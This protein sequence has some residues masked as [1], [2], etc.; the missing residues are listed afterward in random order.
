[1]SW[2]QALRFFL[3]EASAS[4]RRGWRTSFLAVVTIA[5]S[6]FVVG[7]FLLL[8]ANLERVA[9]EWRREARAIVYFAAGAGREERDGIAAQVEAAS[10]VERV[11]RVSSAEAEERFAAAF[12]GL[13]DLLAGSDGEPLPESLEIVYD[14]ERVEP[15]ARRRWLDEL[16]GRAAVEVVDDDHLWLAEIGQLALLL[17][18]LGT[19]LGGAL[20]AA[21]VF[22]IASVI[23]LT[24]Y[25]YRDE[26]AV[27][28]L[29]GATEFVIRGPFLVEGL[30]QGLLGAVLAVAALWGAFGLAGS[31]ALPEVLGSV[32]FGRFLS[33]ASLVAIVALG[34]L[35]GLV[36]AA[37][38]IRRERTGA[39]GAEE[40][41]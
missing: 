26:I 35:A 13:G 10:W 4:L 25:R 7:A 23:R 38:S 21:A 9:R 15:G 24:A 34:G 28:R 30:L 32:L 6:L 8:T 2:L 33:A 37:L 19:L 41:G 36:G 18:G 12:P 39:L 31:R 27:L 22:T 29:V 3:R 14:P 17:R 1:L 40:G 20:L 11:E 16:R 5:V